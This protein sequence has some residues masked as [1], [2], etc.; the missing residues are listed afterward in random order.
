MQRFP[1][2]DAS[3]LI[4]LI[5]NKGSASALFVINRAASV[6]PEFL[7][8]SHREYDILGCVV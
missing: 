1:L 6:R 4:G 3:M 5:S 2:C 8:R 7:E